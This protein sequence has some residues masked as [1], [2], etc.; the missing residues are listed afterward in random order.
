MKYSFNSLYSGDKICRGLQMQVSLKKGLWLLF[1][2]LLAVGCSQ[3]ETRVEQGI[4]EQVL[5]LGNGVEPLDLDP[6]VTT[7]ASEN[8]IHQAL[9]EGLI[10]PHPE[11]LEPEPG[12]A[13]SWD[14]SGDGLVYTFQL[15]KD[16]RWSNGDPV[17]AEDFIYSWK[18]ILNPEFAA[19][20]TFLYKPVKNALAYN[21]GELE[22]FESVGFK[23]RDSHT[24]VIELEYPTPHFLNML[25]HPAWFPVHQPT[26]EKHDAFERRDS[27]WT[28]TGNHV[29]NGPFRLTEWKINQVVSTE[30]NPYYWDGET[31]RLEEIHFYPIDDLNAEERAFLGGQ[32]H[33]TSSL[34]GIKVNQ[35]RGSE[36]LRIDPEIGTYYY[37]F[38]VRKP[39]FDDVSIRR[40]LS[41]S[42]DRDSITGLLASGV[43]A[44]ERLLPPSVRLTEANVLPE[45]LAENRGMHPAVDG[46]ELLF[47]TSDDH[48]MV[49][50]AVQQMWKIKHGVSIELRNQEWKALLATRAEGDY[51]IIRAGWLADFPAPETFLDIWTSTSENNY[52]GWSNETFDDLLDYS[53]PY[54]GL[55]REER[56]AEAERILLEE[57]P[58]I[59]IYHYVIKYLIHPSVRNWHV[60]PMDRHPYKYVYLEESDEN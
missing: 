17:T 44:T 8:K 59:P 30:K 51:E 13:E 53:K 49:A 26:I 57:A 32:L 36:Y 5:H 50:E 40:R 14:I 2:L 34:P 23:A 35:Y 43:I 48:R 9:F 39:P 7:G 38:N 37:V 24:L 58:L 42:I 11:T 16:A 27:G 28:Q 31:V 54:D 18:R 12:V 22:D 33:I 56:I 15:R 10:T 29:G 4:R 46:K 60:T 25:L 52:S 41:A 20:N 3:R 45:E 21:E 47:N 6:Q 55:S 1:A 19:P